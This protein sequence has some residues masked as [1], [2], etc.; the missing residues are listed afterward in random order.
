M[1]QINALFL[2]HRGGNLYRKPAEIIH[3]FVLQKDIRTFFLSS[4][5]VGGC[6]PAQCSSAR[7]LRIDLPHIFVMS[8]VR[9]CLGV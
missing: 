7:F 1:L 2:G 5:D 9:V 3:I 4:F 8:R 6:P